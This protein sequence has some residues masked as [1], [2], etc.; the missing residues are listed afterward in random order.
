MLALAFSDLVRARF[1]YQYMDK[2]PY[3]NLR[4]FMIKSLKGF[5]D[6]GTMFPELFGAALFRDHH[7]RVF[8]D[9][10]FCPLANTMFSHPKLGLVGDVEAVVDGIDGI[11]RLWSIIIMQGAHQ[12]LPICLAVF[13]VLV[14]PYV[15][16]RLAQ[17][18]DLDDIITAMDSWPLLKDA[19]LDDIIYVAQ[20]FE[21]QLDEFYPTWRSDIDP[22]YVTVTGGDEAVAQEVVNALKK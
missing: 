4:K 9:G 19:P 6:H 20:E 3:L 13:K 18:D 5:G 17:E 12:V 16:G 15:V 14:V 1:F 8:Y 22:H 21:Q 11:G 10:V 7:Y 2:Q